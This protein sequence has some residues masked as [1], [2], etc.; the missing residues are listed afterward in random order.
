MSETF[1][2]QIRLGLRLVADDVQLPS[3]GV[4]R[5]FPTNRLLAVVVLAIAVVVAGV[6]AGLS[7]TGT[8]DRSGPAGPGWPIGVIGVDPWGTDGATVSLSQLRADIPYAFPLPDSPLANSG[9]L[10][11][12]WENTVTH[13]VAIYYPSSGIELVYGGTGVDFTGASAKWIQSIG[14]IKSLVIPT[15]TEDNYTHVLVPLPGGHLVIVVGAGAVNDLTSVAASI[16]A[17]LGP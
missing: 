15:G 8:A 11:D 10:G 17:N 16:V 4:G 13:A 2:N 14:G 9:N 7:L 12:I 3:G 1:E 6:W 5:R